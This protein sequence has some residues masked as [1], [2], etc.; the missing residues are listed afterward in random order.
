[1]SN[2]SKRLKDVED[3]NETLSISNAELKD[4]LDHLT[5]CQALS[6][7]FQYLIN[8]LSLFF[9]SSRISGASANSCSERFANTVSKIST[10]DNTDLSE[11]AAK[12]VSKFPSS[13]RVRNQTT[14][15]NDVIVVQGWQYIV[16][17]FRRFLQCDS[18]EDAEIDLTDNDLILFLIDLQM[19]TQQRNCLCHILPSWN[20]VHLS[21]P[22]IARSLK[23]VHMSIE[24]IDIENEN[25]V[26]KPTALKISRIIDEIF[27][28]LAESSG[29]AQSHDE[30]MNSI[31]E[32]MEKKIA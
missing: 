3:T 9:H 4:R 12:I 22:R 16:R 8:L 5:A 30:V 23:R 31:I 11:E 21:I 28:E 10:D 24:V 17:L 14:T 18:C 6:D 15:S 13:N 7:L 1:M 26:R 32:I 29:N 20:K 25:Y 2:L 19:I 27:K